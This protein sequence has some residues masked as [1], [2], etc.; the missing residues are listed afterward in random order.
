[1]L[2][3]YLAMIESEEEKQSFTA[4]YQ[5]HRHEALCVAMRYTR[6]QAMAEDAIQNAFM[7][8]IQK[9]RQYL[10][11]PKPKLRSKLMNIVRFKAIDI[12]RKENGPRRSNLALEEVDSMTPSPE[13]E[14]SVALASEEGFQTLLGC[15]GK[16]D[17]IYKIPCELKYRFGKSNGEIA[18]ILG[19]DER[20]VRQ[21][22]SRA[23][24]MLRVMA[25]AEGYEYEP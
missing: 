6:N 14:L 7:D 18:K 4:M 23:N 25:V 9:G 16:L 15:V 12:M 22:I 17:Y 20:T 19:L 24:K 1:M 2:S 21:R 11:L 3:Y 5:A 13:P 8:I 10:E